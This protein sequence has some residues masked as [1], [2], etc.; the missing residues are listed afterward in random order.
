MSAVLAQLRVM[1][2][3]S[4]WLTAAAACLDGELA[5][6]SCAMLCFLQDREEMEVRH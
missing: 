5:S 3:H 6:V 1:C 4:L 2:S